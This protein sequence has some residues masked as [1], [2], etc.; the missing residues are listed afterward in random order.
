MSSIFQFYLRKMALLVALF[1]SLRTGLQRGKKLPQID[2]DVFRI[3]TDPIK[4]IVQIVFASP[5][6]PGAAIS[7]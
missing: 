6:M 3:H 2:T 5:A 4:N 7:T 1:L